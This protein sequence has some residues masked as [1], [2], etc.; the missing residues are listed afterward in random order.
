M[1]ERYRREGRPLMIIAGE[2]YGAGSSR[3]W[4]AKGVAL[5]GVRAIIARSFERIH[6]INLIGMGVLPIILPPEQLLRAGA[7]DRIDVMRI[8]LFPVAQ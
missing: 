1:A 7:M 4:T 6:R 3:D 2:R 8:M 5:L